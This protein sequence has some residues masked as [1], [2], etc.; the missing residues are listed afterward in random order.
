MKTNINAKLRSHKTAKRSPPCNETLLPSLAS[1]FLPTVYPLKQIPKHSSTKKK[2][3]H[4]Q[5][6]RS[7]PRS[8]RSTPLKGEVVY[9]NRAT[10]I[11]FSW[12]P[13]NRLSMPLVYWWATGKAV[14]L[15]VLPIV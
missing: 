5:T 12:L 15:L 1:T 6:L 9:L 10:L 8:L 3:T 4:I 2:P 11:C 7:H 14:W 13:A